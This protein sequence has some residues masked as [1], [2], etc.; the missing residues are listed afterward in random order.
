MRIEPFL[1]PVF[2]H[3]VVYGKSGTVV[4]LVVDVTSCGIVVGIGK[5]ANERIV[6]VLCVTYLAEAVLEGMGRDFVACGEVRED[7]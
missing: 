2:S 6:F 3:A 5:D 7:Y 4:T 1:I